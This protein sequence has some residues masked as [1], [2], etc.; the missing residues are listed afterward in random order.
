[1]ANP[2]QNT[3]CAPCARKR[4]ELAE[5]AQRAANAARQGDVRAVGRHLIETARV[6]REG[7]A[8]MTGLKPK[9]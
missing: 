6:A 5:A 1:M 9:E 2:H 7:A 3:P 8:M 4:R